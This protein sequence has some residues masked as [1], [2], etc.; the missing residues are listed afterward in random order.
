MKGGLVPLGKKKKEVT[1]E[2]VGGNAEGVTGSCTKIDFYGRTAPIRFELML[3]ESNSCVID[4]T[5][6]K[7]N[8]NT[9]SDTF[10]TKA[11]LSA[12]KEIMKNL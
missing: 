2:I 4:Q 1:I 5:T 10:R 9:N 12:R 7:G 11:P 3:Q 6:L 8:K